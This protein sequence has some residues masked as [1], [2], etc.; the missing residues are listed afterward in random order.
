M[1]SKLEEDWLKGRA[2]L[3]AAARWTPDEI[4]LVAEL[5]FGLAEQGRNEEAI[6]VFEGLAALAPATAY[7]QSAL[8]ALRLRTG[9]LEQSLI[10]LN[11]ALLADATDISALTNKGEVLL[12]LGRAREAEAALE[13]ALDLE[14]E[15]DIA[16]A[17]RARGLLMRLQSPNG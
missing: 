3:G 16:F 6:T 12:L 8:G 9:D 4:R 1:S 11:A 2:S 5:G 7:F 14:S 15:D 13:R 10:H 17:V